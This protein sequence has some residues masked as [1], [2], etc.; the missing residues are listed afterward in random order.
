MGAQEPYHKHCIKPQHLTAL[1]SRAPADAEVACTQRKDAASCDLLE[2]SNCIDSSLGTRWTL[3]FGSK[4]LVS[5]GSHCWVHP[6]DYSAHYLDSSPWCENKLC[7]GKSQWWQTCWTEYTFLSTTQM[8]L[9]N[10]KESCINMLHYL[11]IWEAPSNPARHWRWSGA[12]GRRSAYWSD[13]ITQEV[14]YY[15]MGM[16]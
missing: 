13:Q 16:V 3:E 5:W 14:T 6:C 8:A 4:I 15:T 7:S 2:L 1:S 9:W 12:A 10:K 11:R